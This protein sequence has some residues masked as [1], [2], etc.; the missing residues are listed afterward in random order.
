M[1][2]GA[3]L[4]ARNRKGETPLFNAIRTASDDIVRKMIEQGADALARNLDGDTVLNQTNRDL[5]DAKIKALKTAGLNLNERGGKYSS[6]ALHYAVTEGLDK[7]ILALFANGARSDA[8]DADGEAAITNVCNSRDEAKNTSTLRILLNQSPSSAR[9]TPRRGVG[10]IDKCQGNLEALKL[11]VAEGAD[12]N[13]KSTYWLN[14]N[15]ALHQAAEFRFLKGAEN[16]IAA[17]ADVN[18]RNKYGQTPLMLAVVGVAS[19]T[20]PPRCQT[21]FGEYRR[22]RLQRSVRTP[23]NE[24]AQLL[25]RFRSH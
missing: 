21:A 6:P 8:T 25:F 11:L 23:E 17:G 20:S 24:C 14:E 3:N 2:A 18:S 5:T 13:A 4:N 19:G 16:L 1:K 15:T 9:H 22:R 7:T 10:V 12:V